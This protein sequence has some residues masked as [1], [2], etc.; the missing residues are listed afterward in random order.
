MRGLIYKDFAIFCKCMN[1][2]M[3]AIEVGFTVLLILGAGRYGGLLASVL[4]AIFVGIQN[5]MSITSDDKVRW[6]KY[7]MAM[8][9]G[10]FSV[11]ASKYISVL[12]TLGISVLGSTV[13]NLLSGV[14]Y[15]NFDIFVWGLAILISIF[16][17]LIWTGISLPFAYW[18]G[19]QSAQVMGIIVV[20]PVFCLVKYFEDGAGFSV[21]TSTLSSYVGIAGVVTVLI[22]GVSMAMS[23]MGY[24]RRK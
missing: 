1:K 20:I 7:Q 9:L 16:V 15:Q 17:P 3:I 8:P 13:L 10:E 14:V 11:V 24:A 23:V 19:V 12:C 2:K 4:F 5:V 21:M 22:F 18:F 6:K